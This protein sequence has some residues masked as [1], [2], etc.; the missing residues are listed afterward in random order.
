MNEAGFKTAVA[1]IKT[2]TEARVPF[3]EIEGRVRAA[4]PGITDKD[5]GAAFER[6]AGRLRAEADALFPEADELRQF[7]ELRRN[8]ERE[9]QDANVGG[10]WRRNRR[11]YSQKSASTTR[12]KP[13]RTQL[14]YDDAAR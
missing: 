3:S 2:G 14:D 10:T 5:L 9:S 12:G 1:I 11:S 6:A 4:L 7:K 8:P 13:R